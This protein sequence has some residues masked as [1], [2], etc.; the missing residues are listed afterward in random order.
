MSACPRTS[1]QLAVL[2]GQGQ[3]GGDGGK[4]S[5]Q[6]VAEGVEARQVVGADRF[7]PPGELVALELVIILPNAR[8]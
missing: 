3:A 4:V 7:D 1:D 2:P 5:F 8:T 6:A